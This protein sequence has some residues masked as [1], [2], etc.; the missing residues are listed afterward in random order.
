M[1]NINDPHRPF[2]NSDEEIDFFSRHI[3]VDYENTSDKVEVPSETKA[4][5]LS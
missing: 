5:A 2:A 4:H 3:A 1:A